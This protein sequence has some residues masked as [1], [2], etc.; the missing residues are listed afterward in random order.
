VRLFAARQAKLDLRLAVGVEID[1]QRDQRQ[2]LPVD[3]AG[4]LV[5]LAPPQQQPPLAPRIVVHPASGLV[6][7]DRG[8]DQ[9]HLFAVDRRIALRD[10]AFADAQGFDLGALE[11][12]A[13]LEPVLD[14]IVEARAPVLGDDLG[15][16][17]LLGKGLGHL[18][19]A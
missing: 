1:R 15:F 2:A 17:E 8:V 9:E 19:A 14:E 7:R 16:V 13:R 12:N 4:Q 5:D 10:R 11:R 3:G 6:L 18:V